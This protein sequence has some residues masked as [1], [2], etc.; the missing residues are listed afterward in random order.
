MYWKWQTFVPSNISYGSETHPALFR[1]AQIFSS[2]SPA[3]T[4]KIIMNEIEI[5]KK[6]REREREK[7]KAKWLDFR[8]TKE[9]RSRFGCSLREA[10]EKRRRRRFCYGQRW[11]WQTPFKSHN[12]TSLMR[13]FSNVLTPPSLRRVRIV[14][15]TFK[16]SEFL[17]FRSL[18]FIHYFS[19]AVCS[20]TI[21]RLPILVWILIHLF[22]SRRLQ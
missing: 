16:L 1:P 13:S 2:F 17:L 9:R 19:M 21:A 8:E 22:V 5:R 11:K 12:E 6:K 15:I 14:C 4:T 10:R 3:E 7:W 20:N 18:S